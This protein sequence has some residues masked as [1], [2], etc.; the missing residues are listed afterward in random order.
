MPSVPLP[1]EIVQAL[2]GLRPLFHA[3]SW[4]SFIYLITGL[5]LGQAQ[6]GTV[7]AS[8]LAPAGYNGR[9]VHDFLRRNTWD[10]VAVMVRWTGIV[11]GLLYPEG[12]PPHLFW[13]ID[14][15]YLEK[16][17]GHAMDDVLIH[18]RPHPKTG[19]SRP[20][21]GH[22][23]LRVAPLYQQTTHRFRALLLGGL[24]YVKE[25]TWVE[26]GQQ[27]IA[28][29]PLPEKSHHVVLTDRGLTALKLI[30]GWPAHLFL[31]GRVKRNA[32]FYLP[33][34]A[35]DCKGRGRR[36]RYGKKYRAAAVP[37]AAMVRTTMKIPIAGKRYEGVVYRGT[38]LRRG[39]PSPVD[40]LRA[41]VDGWPPWLLMLTD[42]RV[43]TP[44][45]V[46]AY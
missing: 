24:L 28:Q 7:R 46:G 9:R 2:Q 41:E 19:Q 26:L 44:Q 20:L 1:P 29:L 13:V 14:G 6:A 36:P 4:E 32:A 17:Y 30:K 3:A 10:G 25:A 21:K 42:D 22:G 15:T 39:L 45:A 31:L 11:L 16:R 12:W 8:L 35:A 34:T 33:A 23:M 40:L 27:A 43:S 38:F 37:K 5:L 18:R